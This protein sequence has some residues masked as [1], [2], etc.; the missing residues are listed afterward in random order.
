MKKEVTRKCPVCGKK[1]TAKVANQKYCCAKCKAVVKKDAKKA[2]K[3]ASVIPAIKGKAVEKVIL[4]KKPV[5][6][7]P[8]VKKTAP[9]KPVANK[10]EKKLD[11]LHAIDCGLRALAGIVFAVRL[12]VEQHNKE[13]AQKK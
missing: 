12:I 3:P 2:K 1:F 6:K 4:P 8:K 10:P 5:A 13:L 11:H 7:K 9:K